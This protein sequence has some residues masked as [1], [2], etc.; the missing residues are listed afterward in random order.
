MRT[1]VLAVL[2]ALLLLLVMGAGTAAAGEP[3]QAVGQE[4]ASQQSA[5]AFI[6]TVRNA[7]CASVWVLT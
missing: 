7:W 2:A 5:T 6:R 1:H 4:A 3:T